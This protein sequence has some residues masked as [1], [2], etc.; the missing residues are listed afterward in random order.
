MTVKN[1]IVR[2]SMGTYLGN[3][4]GTVTDRQIKAYAEAAEGG[5][6]LIFMDSLPRR[7][8]PQCRSRP[9]CTAGRRR[10][11]YSP[12]RGSPQMAKMIK[13]AVNIPVLVGHNIFSPE[14]AER[15]LE[16]GRLEEL[17]EREE[18][19]LLFPRD[20]QPVSASRQTDR[21]STA[22]QIEL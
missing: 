17:L 9:F 1:R 11:T 13:A 14:D 22:V 20:S 3:P 4:D 21:Q 8:S 18:E 12:G 16:E 10:Q 5:A 2:N 19:E 7:G 15:L 6:G